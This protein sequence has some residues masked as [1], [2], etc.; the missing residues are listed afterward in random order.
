MLRRPARRQ[1]K[2]QTFLV[3]SEFCTGSNSPHDTVQRDTQ[4]GTS[5]GSYKSKRHYHELTLWEEDNHGQLVQQAGYFP[6]IICSDMAFPCTRTGQSPEKLPDAHRILAKRF[7]GQCI[8]H[9]ETYKCCEDTML[10]HETAILTR[11]N[12]I[13]FKLELWDYSTSQPR[14]YVMQLSSLQSDAITRMELIQKWLPEVG[15]ELFAESKESL[16]G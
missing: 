10:L 14:P 8:G 5:L 7:H 16:V 1:S 15:R 12:L 11:N 3:H 4:R 13:M 9:S 6:L 2:A